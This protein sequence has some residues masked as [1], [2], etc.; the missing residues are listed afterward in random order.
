MEYYFCILYVIT[1]VRFRLRSIPFADIRFLSSVY[2]LY[3][4][5]TTFDM[6]FSLIERQ[7]TLEAVRAELIKLAA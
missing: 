2:Q 5:V 7:K 4:V 1:Y 6:H 3:F